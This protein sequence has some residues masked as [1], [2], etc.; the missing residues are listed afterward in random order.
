MQEHP[1]LVVDFPDIPALLAEHFG[2]DRQAL[3]QEKRAM[4]DT[5]RSA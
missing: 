3:E 2:I 4:L 1:H 5:V